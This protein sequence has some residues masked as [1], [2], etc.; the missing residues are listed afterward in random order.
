MQ[1]TIPNRN[2][3]ANSEGLRS[4]IWALPASRRPLPQPRPRPLAPP[5]PPA[6]PSPRP[7]P[8]PPSPPLLQPGGT[9]TGPLTRL[10]CHF[11]GGREGEGLGADRDA[12]SG[13]EGASLQAA[14]GRPSRSCEKTER[15]E[16]RGS[17]RVSSSPLPPGR[18]RA[19]GG[20]AWQG[21]AL[22]CVAGAV[23]WALR[24]SP[25]WQCAWR[26]KLV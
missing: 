12:Q 25:S 2:A 11:Q 17:R 9:R 20:G 8:R 21:T 24:R 15:E 7:R 18:T 22:L 14:P 19:R 23:G 6:P 3:D 13:E 1:S 10:P 16:R 4:Q 5:R 26:H